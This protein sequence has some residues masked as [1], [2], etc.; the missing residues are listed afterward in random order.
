MLPNPLS[1]IIL[2]DLL[3]LTELLD[4]EIAPRFQGPL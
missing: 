3:L 2:N 4:I 1:S